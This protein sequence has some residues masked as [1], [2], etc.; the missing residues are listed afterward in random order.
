MPKVIEGFRGRLFGLTLPLTTV[1]PKATRSEPRDLIFDRILLCSGIGIRSLG[2]LR[3]AFGMTVQSIY[4]A[5]V[6]LN[7]VISSENHR[8]EGDATVRL[9]FRCPISRAISE[10]RTP[11]TLLAWPTVVGRTRPSFSRL[12]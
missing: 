1:I 4:C 3:V 9:A 6:G 2:S 11:G 10:G 5:Y 8:P 12:S 7:V